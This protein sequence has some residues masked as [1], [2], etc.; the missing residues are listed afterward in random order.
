MRGRR[1]DI[2]PFDGTL[3]APVPPSSIPK[4]AAKHWRKI[5]GDVAERGHLVEGML[6]TLETLVLALWTRDECVKA[7]KKDGSFVRTKT[8]Q[9]KPHPAMGIM[10]KNQELIARLSAEFGLTS[11][12]RS[13]KTLK[14]IDKNGEEN[15]ATWAKMDL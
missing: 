11:A 2:R 6:P 7:L 4:D 13:R 12:S 1:A 10:A 3:K 8:E 14:P 9:P 5:V 15:K